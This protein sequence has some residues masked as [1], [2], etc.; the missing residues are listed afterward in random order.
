MFYFHFA[1]YRTMVRLAWR[2]RNP[3]ARGYAL[4]VLL[5]AVPVVSAF[6]ALC[7]ALDPVF[8]PGLMRTTVRAPVFVL[9]HARSG[10]TLIHRLLSKDRGRFST[11]ALYEMYFPSL[12]QKWTLRKLGAVDRHHLGGRIAAL[13]RRWED[14][15]YGAVRQVHRMGLHEP[16]ED[17]MVLYYSCASGYWITKLPYLGDLDFYDVDAWPARKRRRL[18]NF[19]RECVR[20]QLYL[21]GAEKTHL[22]KNPI[23]AGR[24][25]ALI[26]TFPDARIVVPVRNPY[27][28]IPSLLKLVRGGWK[29]LGWDAESQA[30]CLAVLAEQSFHTYRHPLEVLERHPE[31]PHAV[32]DYRDLVA[33]PAAAIEHIYERL[34]IPIAPEYQALLSSEEKR[35]RSHR[36]G[37]TYSLAEFDL[38]A[39]AIRL[40]LKDLFDRFGWDAATPSGDPTP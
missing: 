29:R 4:A 23:F 21:N 2:E 33:D 32:V 35:V 40:R 7:F 18:M 30:R 24:V 34:A 27:E 11:F 9:G 14:Q 3:R 17:D 20:R 8:F 19:Y 36:S 1:N 31:T 16:E 5:L 37:H 12:L 15:R 39:D 22:S 26:E 25:E 13:L 6:H 38:E 28:T 10:T